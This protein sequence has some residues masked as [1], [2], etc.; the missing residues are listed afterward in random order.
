MIA[1]TPKLAV[2]AIS[3]MTWMTWMSMSRI[4]M[5]PMVSL[6]SAIP[7]GTSRRR[8]LARAHV[9]QSAP[10]NTYEERR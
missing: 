7:P 6:A 8:K 5:K 4:V 9:G 3:W 10:W 1:A 2:I